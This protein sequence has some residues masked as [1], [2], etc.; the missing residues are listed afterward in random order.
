METN[1]TPTSGPSTIDAPQARA[2]QTLI[3]DERV[4]LELT[5]VPTAAGREMHVARWLQRWFADRPWAQVS[6]DPPG[7]MHVAMVPQRADAVARDRPPVYFTAHMDHPAMVVEHIEGPTAE[8]S[9]RGGVMGPYLRGAR[10]VF[11]G[12]AGQRVPGVL[13]G[14][15][16]RDFG[17]LTGYLATTDGADASDVLAVG[18]I[19]V[20]DLPSPELADGLLHTTACDDLMA[21][22]CAL[23]AFDRLA[24]LARAGARTMDCRLLLTRAEEIGFIGAIAACKQGTMA[25]G[26]SVIALE[27]SRAMGDVRIGGGPIVRVGDRLSV[28]DPGLTGACAKV[29]ERVFGRPALPRATQREGE[30]SGR[31]WQRRLMA[32]GACEAS[33]FCAAGYRA[34]C[35]CLPLGNYHNMADLDAVQSG[36]PL[37]ENRQPRLAREHVALDDARGLVDLLVGCGTDLPEDG[38]IDELVRTLWSKHASVLDEA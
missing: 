9:L 36:R 34:T 33:V 6:T 16:G 1:R 31:A 30:L 4:F 38:G 7:N 27:N 11:V 19:A 2:Q 14:T 25:R 18:D 23:L 32:G 22:A 24:E 37:P 35:L 13:T 12:R 26:A 15:S 8:L 3:G 29:A 28:F 17:G 10:L 20:W 5:N 21:L